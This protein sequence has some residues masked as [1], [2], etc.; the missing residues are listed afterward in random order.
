[1]S[2]TPR[3]PQPASGESLHPRQRAHGAS[4]PRQE[5]LVR[6]DKSRHP[7]PPGWLEEAH[8]CLPFSQLIW[9]LSESTAHASQWG[10]QRKCGSQSLPPQQ[11]AVR[12]P[13]ALC[14]PRT[15]AR[16]SARLAWHAAGSRDKEKDS[17][18]PV[19]GERLCFSVPRAF[20]REVLWS[21]LMRS[22]C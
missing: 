1:M 13:C 19:R 2:Q 22:G 4:A 8:T 21:H 15:G 18:E 7:A 9:G 14:A 10:K 5:G 20:Q 16:A 17:S 12:A 6:V 3:A 11:D